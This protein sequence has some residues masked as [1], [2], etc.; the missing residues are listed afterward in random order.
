[1]ADPGWAAGREGPGKWKGGVKDWSEA[2]SLTTPRPARLNS[3]PERL[4]RESP[5]FTLRTP[6]QTPPGGGQRAP[7]PPTPGVTGLLPLNPGSQ[8]SAP[9][10]QHAGSS[11]LPPA[12]LPAGPPLPGLVL[13]PGL[14]LSFP[15]L[16]G[17][18]SRL[19][20][21]LSITEPSVSRSVSLT[22]LRSLSHL[23]P[24]PPAVLQPL[25]QADPTWVRGLGEERLQPAASNFSP[26]PCLLT[27]EL[28]PPAPSAFPGCWPTPLHPQ[29]LSRLC[30]APPQPGLGPPL[31][32]GAFRTSWDP[33]LALPKARVEP[34][35]NLEAAGPT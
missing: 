20:R 16:C 14:K 12:P 35:V 34:T 29:W 1:M 24:S 26:D 10:V 11:A 7:P 23:P 17:F 4:S 3:A 8:P 30:W 6:P 31:G 9:A 13:T 21:F 19:C 25:P 27:P 2:P 33:D 15:S 28:P 32:G 18:S 5:S 22:Q